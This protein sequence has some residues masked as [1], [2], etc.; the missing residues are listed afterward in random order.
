MKKLGQMILPSLLLC[1]GLISAAATIDEQIET[2]DG[3]HGSDGV[4]QWDDVPTIAG[5]DAFIH[6]DALFIYRERERPCAESKFRQGDTSRAATT[7]CDITADFS[8]D[9]IEAIAEHYAELEFA[10][11]IQ[12]FDAAL[13]ETGAAVHGKLCDKCH[14]D[15]GSNAEDESGILAGQWM[16]YMETAFAQYASGERPQDKKMKEKMDKLSAADVTALLH[17]YA[18][19]Q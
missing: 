18:S 1:H 12:E 17:Y 15:G 4:S 13:A 5:I 11:A 6:S 19:Q 2:C 8:D 9:D 10:P 14:T 7:M 3:C 16:T